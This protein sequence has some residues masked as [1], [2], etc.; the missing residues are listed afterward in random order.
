MVVS[1]TL[2]HDMNEQQ[3]NRYLGTR[4]MHLLVSSSLITSGEK[5]NAKLKELIIKI[6][7]HYLPQW[8]STSINEQVCPLSPN[9]C[10][11]CSNVLGHVA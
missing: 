9:H 3:L 6:L 10:G 11:S 1:E 2:Y 8:R 5:L 4:L 7:L